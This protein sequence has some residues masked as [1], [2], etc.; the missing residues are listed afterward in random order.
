MDRVWRIIVPPARYSESEDIA[1]FMR[2][3]ADELCAK[4][5]QDYHGAMS[6]GEKWSMG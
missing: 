3:V 5:P 6:S 4:E 2:Y 1:G